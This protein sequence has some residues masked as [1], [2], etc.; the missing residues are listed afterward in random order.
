ML[1]ALHSQKT[2]AFACFFATVINLPDRKLELF[3]KTHTHTHDRSGK[4]EEIVAEGFPTVSNFVAPFVT[5]P[6]AQ[7]V[8]YMCGA[9]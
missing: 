7:A 5:R 2:G 8:G 3:P 1:H 6:T 9:N 4:G